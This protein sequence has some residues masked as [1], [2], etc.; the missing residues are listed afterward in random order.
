MSVTC[1]RQRRMRTRQR[2]RKSTIRQKDLM[3]LVGR[4]VGEDKLRQLQESLENGRECKTTLT[5]KATTTGLLWP[6]IE[7]P[8]RE[9]WWS[10]SDLSE[11]D[12]DLSDSDPPTMDEWCGNND[13]LLWELYLA[14]AARMDALY[15]YL[16]MRTSST[17]P[18]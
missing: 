13:E 6:E 9:L 4:M 1:R 11:T 7:M 3:S 15:P 17:R 16:R 8:E 5:L 10:D 12:S 18:S 2:Q 14:L